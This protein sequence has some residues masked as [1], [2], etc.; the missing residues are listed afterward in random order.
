MIDSKTQLK[1]F[2]I[3]RLLFKEIKEWEGN[4]DLYEDESEIDGWYTSTQLRKIA[5]VMDKLKDEITLLK[6]SK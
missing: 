6:E 2:E 5:D 3:R 4:I 1:I